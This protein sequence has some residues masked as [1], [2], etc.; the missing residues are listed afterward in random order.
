MNLFTVPAAG[1]VELSGIWEFA[2]VPG[3]LENLAVETVNF[4]SLAAVPGCFDLQS[5]C[6][7]KRGTGLY[8]CKVRCGGE[9]ELVCH[10]VGLRGLLFW[11]GRQIASV[12][13]AFSQEKIRFD[14]GGYGIHELV[15]A[16]NNEFDDSPGSLFRRNYDFYAHG[17]IYRK[18]TMSALAPLRLEK[19]QVIPRNT[20]TGEVEVSLEVSG[21]MSAKEAFLSWDEGEFLETL[22]LENGVGK[23]LF[24]VPGHKLWTPETP[25]LHQLTVKVK[26][27]NFNASFGI[28]SITAAQGK[29]FLN[30]KE[31]KIAGINRHDAH[32]DFGYAVPDDIRLRDLQML[33]E[34]GYNCIRGCHYPQSEDFLDLCDRV[35]MMVWEESLAWG[36]R[37]LSM[38]DPLFKERQVRETEKMVRKSINHPCVIMWGFLNECSSDFEFSRDLISSLAAAIR[39]QDPSRPITYGSMFLTRDV[40]LD[41]VDVISFNTY[42]CWYREGQE[43]YFDRENLL[44]HLKELADFAS[45]PEYAEKPLLISEIGAEAFPGDHSGLRWSEEYQSE[46]LCEVLRHTLGGGRYSGAFLWQFCDI[47][48]YIGNTCQHRPGGFNRKGLVDGSRRPKLSFK[49]TGKVIKDCLNK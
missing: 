49:E 18:V 32:P 27:Q 43:Q 5:G 35:G 6:F 16:V 42:P 29:L 47:R 1:V 12:E 37:E 7:M 22:K 41:L 46:L 21:D 20:E 44:S 38:T 28:R 48:T 10:G 31:L 24:C 34:Q 2:F 17:G 4:D 19:L 3:A 9:N 26:D 39:K 13:A 25:H 36:N 45:A 30:G 40:C 8:R 23:A 15:I 33:K 11:D 14:A